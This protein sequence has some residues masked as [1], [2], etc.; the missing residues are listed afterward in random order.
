VDHDVSLLVPEIWCRM[1]VAERD[2]EFLKKQGF[3]EKVE[4][5]PFQ[6]RTV[7]ASRLGFRITSLFVDR[8]LGR[9]FETPGAVFPAEMLRPEQQGLDLFA[10]GVD[11]IVESQRRVALYYFE[12]GSVEAACPPL[13]ALLHIMAHGSYQG[14]GVDAPQ[15]RAMFQ[16]ETMLASDWYQERLATKQERDRALWRRHAAAL[17]RFR[18]GSGRLARCGLGLDERELEER[19]DLVRRELERVSSPAYLRELRGTIG[20][21]PFHGQMP[22]EALE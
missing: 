18:A 19:L 15:L 16:R 21:D 13:K 9:I 5:V 20:A 1:R 7:L 17:E 8:F 3:L 12:D 14:S 11:A 4:D 22:R 6:G 2:P 10:E